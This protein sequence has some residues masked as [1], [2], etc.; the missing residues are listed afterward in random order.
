MTGRDPLDDAALLLIDGNNLLHREAGA[1]GA[2][3]V[4][5]LTGVT[6]REEADAASPDKRPTA[7][8]ADAAELDARLGELSRQRA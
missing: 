4:L 7:I 2:R 8:A 5:M 1:A 6:T 3:S